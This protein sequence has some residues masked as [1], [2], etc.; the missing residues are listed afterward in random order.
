MTTAL[1]LYIRF[2]GWQGDTIDQAM[3]DFSALDL[4]QQDKFCNRIMDNLSDISD[5]HNAKWFMNKRLK[6]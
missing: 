1:E 2:T 6:T 3:A 4:S 5:L